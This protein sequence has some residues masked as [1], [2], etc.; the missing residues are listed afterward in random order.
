MKFDIR[1]ECDSQLYTIMRDLFRQAEMSSVNIH[2]VDPLG[3]GGYAEY[4]RNRQ[5]T[6]RVSPW[7]RLAQPQLTRD[8][9]QI[10]AENTGGVAI[11]ATDKVEARIDGVFRQDSSVL[12]GGVPVVE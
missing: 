8:W 1:G 7:L 12:P 3:P 6:G 5:A 4:V 9:L 2:T 10:T 11:L